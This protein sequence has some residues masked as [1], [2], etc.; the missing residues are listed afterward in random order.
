MK[1]EDDKSGALRRVR[2]L[3]SIA[4]ATRNPAIRRAM[5]ARMYFEEMII[6]FR[7][8]GYTQEE[9]DAIL[10]EVRHL[11]RTTVHSPQAWLKQALIEASEAA[12][13]GEKRK[14]WK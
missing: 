1:E 10:E 2:G 7:L 4:G 13:R 14:P 8:L 9:I 3:A 5:A 12:G 11:G 6:K